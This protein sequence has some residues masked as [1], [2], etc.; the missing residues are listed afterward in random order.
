MPTTTMHMWLIP[1]SLYTLQKVGGT[2]FNQYE[3][4]WWVVITLTFTLWF[5]TN[6]KA[7]FNTK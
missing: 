4:L 7:T 2:Q 5:F 1:T 6:F 3:W